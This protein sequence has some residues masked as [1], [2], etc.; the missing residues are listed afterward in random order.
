MI[1]PVN[2]EVQ[3]CG[4][5]PLSSVLP[6]ALLSKKVLWCDSIEKLQCAETWAKKNAMKWHHWSYR[7]LLFQFETVRPS[8]VFILC[9]CKKG[10]GGTALSLFTS[11]RGM[12]SDSPWS[13]ERCQWRCRPVKLI[14]PAS[15]DKQRR[16]TQAFEAL[17][18]SLLIKEQPLSS[19]VK[20]P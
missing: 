7:G 4:D 9:I 18:R 15:C 1:S 17:L 16:M 14:T 11:E 5:I 2:R 8:S 6:M 13:F 3:L 12:L 10:S 20:N 19:Y